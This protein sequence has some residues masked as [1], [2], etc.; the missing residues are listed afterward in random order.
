[1][2]K[3]VGVWL[4]DAETDEWHRALVVKIKDGG[5]AAKECEV[6]LRLTEGPKARTETSMAID[7]LALEEEKI[8]GVLLAN[9]ADMVRVYCCF[10]RD[11]HRRVIY[12][13]VYLYRT[14]WRT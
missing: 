4:R 12:S 5:D 3:G 10:V 1:M 11:G 7:V 6:T 9:S 14:W 2:E 13:H 8:D